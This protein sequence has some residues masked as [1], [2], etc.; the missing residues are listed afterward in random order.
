MA[1]KPSEKV[2]LSGQSRKLSKVEQDF[3]KF[4]EKENLARVQKLRKIRRSNLITGGVL[5]GSV[6][7]IYLYTILSVKQEKFLDDFNE[8]EKVS[9]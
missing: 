2:E 4:I 9:D 7:G 8:P 6:F 1:E 5:A 3:M